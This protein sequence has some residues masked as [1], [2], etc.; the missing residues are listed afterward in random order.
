MGTPT[1]EGVVKRFALLAAVA[2]LWPTAVTASAQTAAAPTKEK[3]K[4][5]VG[6]DLP[7]PEVVGGEPTIVQR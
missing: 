4:L 1:R 6:F 2:V 7:A 3:G 5:I